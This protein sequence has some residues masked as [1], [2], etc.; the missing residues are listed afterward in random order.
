MPQNPADRAPT[1]ESTDPYQEPP[2]STVDDWLGQRV[3]RDEALADELIDES[4]GD[5]A[6]AERRFDEQSEAKE[7]DET[8]VQ[9]ET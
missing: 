6:E 5:L 8:H 7:W 9:D 2:N 4:D 1:G 3:Q